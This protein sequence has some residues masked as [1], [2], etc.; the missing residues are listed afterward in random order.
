MYPVIYMGCPPSEP[1]ESY[2]DELGISMSQGMLHLSIISVTI[3][4]K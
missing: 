4:K 3:L 2:R 1:S